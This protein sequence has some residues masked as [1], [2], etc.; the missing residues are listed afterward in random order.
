MKKLLLILLCLP[1]IGFG[2]DK[3]FAEDY[4]L[5]SVHV[6]STIDLKSIIEEF[7]K[8][9]FELRKS[10]GGNL[11]CYL[12]GISPVLFFQKKIGYN[13]GWHY[14]LVHTDENPSDVFIYKI[15]NYIMENAVRANNAVK[16]VSK[17][18]TLFNKGIIDKNLSLTANKIFYN[19]ETGMHKMSDFYPNPTYVDVKIYTIN[20][21]DCPIYEN[22]TIVK[23]CQF[24][25]V[26]GNET[27]TI[28]ELDGTLGGR[29]KKLYTYYSIEHVGIDAFTDLLEETFALIDAIEGKN[30]IPIQ[31]EG[32]MN[33]I[34][35]K[36]GG[37]SYKFLLDTGASDMV[38]NTEMKDY[39][40]QAGVL[41]SSDFGQSRIYEIANGQKVR[42]KT[43]TLNSIE[44]N[45]NKFTDIPIAI[46]DNASLLLG[47]SF[48]DRFN[49]RINNNF[50]ELERK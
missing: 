7:K 25:L 1:M 9:D 27:K 4:K 18:E 17:W 37:K 22:G 44:I 30:K 24:A 33:F 2:Q 8:D 20:Y 49:W 48:L 12:N 29:Y 26:T 45:G 19:Y 31:K 43:A 6:G 42:F 16:K 23:D 32:K 21:G 11:F 3:N 39:L 15:E 10:S 13:R 28:P 35:I 34:S 36:I 47:M 5:L 14:K 50:L 40:M 38:I 41:K 46:G